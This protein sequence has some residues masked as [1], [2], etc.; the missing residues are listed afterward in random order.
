[1]TVEEQ[2][3]AVRTGNVVAF[4]VNVDERERVVV[5]AEIRPEAATDLRGLRA[6]VRRVVA[7]QH[8]IHV[9]DVV[10]LRRGTM[11]KTTSG[12]LQRRTCRDRYHSG[13]LIVVDDES[14]LVEGRRRERGA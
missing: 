2:V 9:H 3:P 5:V 12:K 10:F 13:A 7:A 4:G 11:P 8:D 14:D 6:A 1:M